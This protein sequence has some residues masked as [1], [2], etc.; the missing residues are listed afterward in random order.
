MKVFDNDTNKFIDSTKCILVDGTLYRNDEM[1]RKNISEDLSMYNDLGLRD[2][3]DELIYSE[4]SIVQFEFEF[5]NIIRGYF[6]FNKRSLSYD[7]VFLDK[8]EDYVSINYGNET[9]SRNIKDFK[10]IDTI[11][12]NK[13]GL[14]K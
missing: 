12:E 4:C 8:Y 13:L 6:Q 3:N 5:Y 14:I 11:Q 2:I 7:I 10:I 9:Y 1:Y